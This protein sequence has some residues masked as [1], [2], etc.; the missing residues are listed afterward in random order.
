[1]SI[2][3]KA[4]PSVLRDKLREIIA[5]ADKKASSE[6]AAGRIELKRG[7]CTIPLPGIDVP[8]HSRVLN[9][10]VPEFHAFLSK[11]VGDI[12]PD[13][14]INKYIPNLVAKPFQL[15]KE[16]AQLILDTTGSPRLEKMLQNWDKDGW[17]TVEKRQ[18]LAKELLLLLLSHQFASPVRWIET[19]DV[20]FNE[21][22][23]FERLVEFGPA[24]TLKGMA[25]KTAGL[26]YAA[27]D[28][29]KGKR[30]AMFCHSSDRDKIYYNFADAEADAVETTPAGPSAGAITPAAAPA[31]AVAAPAPVP[32]PAA[33]PASAAAEVPDEPLKAVDTLR[34]ILAQKLKK[35][36]SDIPLSKAIKDLVGGK[37]T[38][39]N[40]LVASL[41]E[42]FSSL[43]ERGEE[44]PLDE[45]GG[46]L[47][48]GYSG[49]MGK[50]T[51]GLVSRMVG[52][53][54][55]G[56]FNLASAKSH[57]QKA[58]GLGP[59]RTDA[60]LLVSLTQEPPKR[61]GSEAE[62]KAFLDTAA[63]TYAQHAG[64]T[65]SQGGGS[66]GSSGGGGGGAT[67][68]A[69]ELEKIQGRH[70][71][72]ARR[73]IE[74]LQRYL[75]VDG[76][77]GQR[78]AEGTRLEVKALQ[79]QLD[80]ISREHGEEYTNMIRP[81][82]DPLKARH[83]A[84]F[85]NWSRQ[86]AQHLWYDIISGRLTTVDREI[87]QRCLNIISRADDTLLHLM[88]YTI[89]RVDPE[90]GPTYAL[91]K[92]FGQMLMENCREALPSPPIYKEVYAPTAPHTE[93]GAK[94]E[95]IYSEV[96]REGV[97][98]L[99]AYVQEMAHGKRVGPQVNV[100]LARE[101]M[102]K[103]WTL[104]R[105]E[106][107]FTKVGKTT[108]KS[109]YTEV[110]R[111]LGPAG[112]H[113]RIRGSSSRRQSSSVAHGSRPTVTP[114]PFS[115]A[116]DRVPYLNVKRKVGGEWQT[117][118]QLTGVYMTLLEDM[119]KNGVTF[120]GQNALLTGVG[121]GSIALEVA[122]GLLAGG[123]RVIITTSS[124]SRATLDFYKEI[125]QKVG[126]RG[127]QLTVVPFNGASK[128]D[129]NSLVTYI[130]ESLRVDLDILIPFAAIPAYG[131]DVSAID[132]RAE[133]AF[134]AMMTNVHRLLGAVR[135]VK[136]AKRINTRPTVVL[137]PLS[138]NH[139]SM[140]GDGLYSESKI[141]LET[142]SNRA[143][144][145]GWAEYVSIVGVVIGWCRG[146]GL[147]DA[148]NQIAAKIEAAGLRTFSSTEMSFNLLGCLHPLFRAT[149]QVEPIL[150]D[151]SG[152]FNSV[153]DLAKLSTRIRTDIANESARRRAI[154]A[155]DAADYV[156]IKGSAAEK[157]HQTRLVQARAQHSFGFPALGPWRPDALAMLRALPARV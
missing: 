44:L 58:W 5:E 28:Q 12:N 15:T 154:A 59:G 88:A 156:V 152:G 135:S 109:M 115:L 7:Y 107:S 52:G 117:S 20:F 33:A 132:D 34:V 40:E 150:A 42:E 119:A 25:Q 83:F 90:L 35:Q 48:A 14:L 77:A 128:E 81:K 27:A 94:G 108:I 32:V 103:L 147:M 70:D 91:A 39:Q 130:Y 9:G 36:L 19:Q 111:S 124:Y 6:A 55:P 71:E 13:A 24:P 51:S 142:L 16:Y 125:F 8:F 1:M 65:L 137:L 133:V 47:G 92:Q 82:F 116:D 96:K 11:R 146:T 144:S 149:A 18:R 50:Y 68:S 123:A 101:Q 140:G 84:S 106:P 75:G 49:T 79:D 72:H 141:G 43:P 134:R 46:A 23:S 31:P 139:G 114:E 74:I 62:A 29:A 80:A 17:G 78:V 54:L 30:R 157:L 63:Q 99:E 122:K 102:A 57:L 87:T 100:E 37:S 60:V 3:Q 105:N 45:L 155:D 153:P 67:I 120:Q 118:K 112:R 113:P 104:I 110:V 86:D 2:L 97:R 126:A 148:N 41:G 64:I 53:K 89:E 56:G 143:I 76:R 131:R 38:L 61:L 121:K 73:Q 93:I 85:W 151:L 127:S 22:Y 4:D 138:P 26:K 66:A 21:P 10:G 145:E 98:K 129:V 95:V 69:E 136:A